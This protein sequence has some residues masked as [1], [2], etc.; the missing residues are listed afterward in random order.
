M[1]EVSTD[2]SASFVTETVVDEVVVLVMVPF[3]PFPV[4]P[5]SASVP[6]ALT[7]TVSAT[8]SGGVSVGSCGSLLEVDA[9]WSDPAS[10]AEDSAS[11]SVNTTVVTVVVVVVTEGCVVDGVG[12]IDDVSDANETAHQDEG[13]LSAS[14]SGF[15]S[16]LPSPSFLLLVSP[17]DDPAE[18]PLALSSVFLSLPLSSEGED[19]GSGGNGGDGGVVVVSGLDG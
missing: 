9:A 3:L 16:D 17:L 1:V 14:E 7:T 18:S 19:T 12:P 5:L 15:A 2:L 11:S 13:A 6:A 4:V 8:S 10:T